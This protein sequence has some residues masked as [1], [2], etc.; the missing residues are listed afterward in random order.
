MFHIEVGKAR[1][2]F[3][4]KEF[5][6]RFLERCGPSLEKAGYV[7][8]PRYAIRFLS[9]FGD[10]VDKIIEERNEEAVAAQGASVSAYDRVAQNSA[11]G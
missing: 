11:A 7:I 3:G 2:G 5:R 8:N 1:A 4:Q 6:D 9:K 10:D